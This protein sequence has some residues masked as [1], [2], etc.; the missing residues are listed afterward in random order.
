MSTEICVDSVTAVR[1]F[2]REIHAA[3]EEGYDNGSESAYRVLPSAMSMLKHV[4]DNLLQPYNLTKYELRLT[5]N[6]RGA[7]DA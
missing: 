1:E 4:A 7:S 5:I 2:V 6:R 3:L